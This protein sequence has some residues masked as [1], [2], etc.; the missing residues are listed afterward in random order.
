MPGKKKYQQVLAFD[1]NVR[2]KDQFGW[3]PLSVMRPGRGEKW[4]SVIQDTVM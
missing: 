1:E 2:V 3:V 4:R